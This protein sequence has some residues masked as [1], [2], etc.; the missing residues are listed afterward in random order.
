MQ[1][2]RGEEEGCFVH[3]RCCERDEV[4]AGG[5]LAPR[6]VAVLDRAAVRAEAQAEGMR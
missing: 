4:A 2:T 5:G 6:A 1:E 3:G